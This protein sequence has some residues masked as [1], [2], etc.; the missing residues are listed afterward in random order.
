MRKARVWAV[1]VAVTVS[2]SCC[3]VPSTA[4]GLPASHQPVWTT[5][6]RAVGFP[7]DEWHT[8]AEFEATRQIAF[9]SDHELVVARDSGPFAKP[10]A[11][12]AFVLDT[13]N[14]AIVG[15]ASWV[16]NLW[17]FLFATAKGEYAVVTTEGMA[18]YSPGLKQVVTSVS[19]A[20][21]DKAS[22]DGKYLAAE[23]TIPGHGVIYFID[24]ATL[25]PTGAEIRDTYAWSAGN[26]RILATATRSGKT[27]VE[28]DDGRSPVIEYQSDCGGTRPQFLAQGFIALLGCGRVDVVSA[29]GA[30]VLSE[31]LVGG[32]T[33]LAI[34]SRNGGRFAVLQQFEGPGDPPG[35]CAERITVFDLNL[36]RS[37]FVTD[38]HD[39]RN[40]SV[41]HSSGIALSP[42]GSFLAVNSAG[43]VRLFSLPPN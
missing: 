41:G 26:N 39:L 20:A 16:S 17:P 3:R 31:P 23:R 35:I 24:S 40:L 9:G 5:D 25:K 38:T 22:P 4:S 43:V 30:M 12:Q 13:R 2:V 14:G 8:P 29:S 33:Y 37:I 27:I 21:A 7:G 32:P 18:L 6:L 1:V 36:R 34:A 42:S 15:R 11:V 10:N 28:S 19:D